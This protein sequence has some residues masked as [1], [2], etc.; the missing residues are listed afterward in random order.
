ME[1]IGDDRPDVLALGCPTRRTLELLSGT[2]T[3]LVVHV[4]A[5]GTHRYGMLKKR[6]EGITHKMLAQTLRGLERDG[7]LRRRV[8]AVVPPKVEYTLTPLGKTLVPVLE[9]L[10]RW[11]EEHDA[12]VEAARARA[13]R[14]DGRA[15]AGGQ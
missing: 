5:T 8:Y 15:D 11:S 6:I 4:L 9:R 12:A 14:A 2:W 7:I 10:C 1:S 13:A 3:V